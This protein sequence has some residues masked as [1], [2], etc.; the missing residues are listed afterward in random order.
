M[1]SFVYWERYSHFGI[2]T[3]A[4]YLEA[5]SYHSFFIHSSFNCPTRCYMKLR[6]CVAMWNFGILMFLQ[7]KWRGSLKDL[8]KDLLNV[9]HVENSGVFFMQKDCKLH[10][11]PKNASRRP[12]GWLCLYKTGKICSIPEVLKI[13]QKFNTLHQWMLNTS[14]QRISQEVHVLS[15]LPWNDTGL[16]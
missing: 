2:S 1:F 14:S 7:T 3:N 10:F 13:Q 9:Y 4:C 16:F 6:I 8:L 5:T 12:A 15:T 11:N